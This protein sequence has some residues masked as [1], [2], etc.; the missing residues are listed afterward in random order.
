VLARNVAEATVDFGFGF[1]GYY[2]S[3]YD[4]CGGGAAYCTLNNCTLT[5]NS[6]RSATVVFSSTP[7]PTF[8]IRDAFGGGAVYCTLN[9]CTITGNSVTEPAEYFEMYSVTLDDDDGVRGGGGVCGCRLTNCALSNNSAE[10]SSGYLFGSGRGIPLVRVATVGGGALDSTLFNCTLTGNYASDSGGG[11]FEGAQNN[12]ILF[13]N[14]PDG[15]N[16]SPGFLAGNNWIG[17][18]LFADSAGRLQSNSPC[19]NA[20]NNAYVVGTIDLDGNPRIKGGTVDIGAY[21]FQLPVS[22]ISYAWLQHYGLPIDSNTDS[23]DADGDGMN[24]WQEWIA[25]TDPTNA[26]SLLRLL[27]P[28]PTPPGLLLTWNG[29]ANHEYFVERATS[30]VP[31]LTFSRLRSDVPGVVGTTTFIDPAPPAADKAFYRIGTDSTNASSPLWLQAPIFVPWSV[32]VSWTSV[33]GHSYC[34]ERST[35]LTAPSAFTLLAT[36]IYGQSGITSYVDTNAVG[37]GPFF[38]RVGVQN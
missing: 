34:L 22:R 10:G 11:A 5:G 38:Y 30:L 26:T 14:N 7:W 31:P 37:A 24:N 25:G 27:P 1:G 4:A 29:E 20:G 17:N 21:E 3:A 33:S 6:V 19:I 15:D 18:P 35:G 9:N 8:S 13:S 23:S 28:V 32:T 12:C 2:W 16:S 36:N